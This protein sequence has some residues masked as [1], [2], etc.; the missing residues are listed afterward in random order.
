M[1]SKTRINHG[2]TVMMTGMMTVIRERRS[3]DDDS[4]DPD[5]KPGNEEEG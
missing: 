4:V 3:N 5:D 1:G 2:M